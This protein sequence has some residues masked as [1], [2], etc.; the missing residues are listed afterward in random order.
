MVIL[1][2]PSDLN[3]VNVLCETVCSSGE[4]QGLAVTARSVCNNI[5][6]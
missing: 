6:A 5:E 3:D 4:Q 2:S 1:W